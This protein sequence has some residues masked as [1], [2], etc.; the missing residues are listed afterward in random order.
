MEFAM[1][2]PLRADFDATELRGEAK[3]SK[4]GGQARRLVALAAIYVGSTRTEAAKIRD[5]LAETRD[6]EGVTGRISIDEN[7]NAAKSGVILK[8]ENGE[9]KM[10]QEVTP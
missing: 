10:V 1:P 6:F 8:I 2:I 7:R 9:P 5:A 4:D 3:K